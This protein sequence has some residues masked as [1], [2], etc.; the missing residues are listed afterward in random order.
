[1]FNDHSLANKITGWQATDQRDVQLI[2]I[3]PQSQ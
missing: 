1:M 2:K 3:M